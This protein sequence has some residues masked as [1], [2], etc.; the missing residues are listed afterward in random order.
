M[1]YL[2]SFFSLLISCAFFWVVS[3]TA[4]KC[5]EHVFSIASPAVTPT[6]SIFYLRYS[7]FSSLK[8]PFGIHIYTT[9]SLLNT[10]I[11]SSTYLNI[12]HVS[13]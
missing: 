13:I 6:W 7:I 9:I 5:T 10:L 2:S 3:V 12:W 4:L 8:I 11:F 1:L